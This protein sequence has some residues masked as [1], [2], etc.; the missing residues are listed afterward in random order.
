MSSIEALERLGSRLGVR[1]EAAEDVSILA[2]PVELRGLS[3]PNS[4]AVHPMEG[5]DGD[6]QGR[7][8]KLTL[9]RYERFAS[10][11]AGLLWVEA[12]AVVPEGRANARQ[13]WLNEKSKDSFRAMVEM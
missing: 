11:G 3:I 1:I 5:C 12:T 13:L 7:P 4:L 8:S 9:R 6:S 10:G 2:E